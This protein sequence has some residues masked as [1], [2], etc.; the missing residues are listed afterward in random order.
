MSDLLLGRNHFFLSI[1]SNEAYDTTRCTTLETHVFRTKSHLHTAPSVC[2]SWLQWRAKVTKTRI[3]KRKQQRKRIATSVNCQSSVA[4]AGSLFC[5]NMSTWILWSNLSY[6]A[7]SPEEQGYFSQNA[8]YALNVWS[9]FG[10][11]CRHSSVTHA[12]SP[13]EITPS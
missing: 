13:R 10:D 4:K 3:K 5:G 8:V 12:E 6:Y 9:G 1:H 2:F 7:N 11:S